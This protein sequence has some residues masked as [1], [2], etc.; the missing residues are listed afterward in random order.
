MSIEEL[1]LKNQGLVETQQSSGVKPNNVSTEE[2]DT[3]G[4]IIDGSS[5]STAS[6]T[7]STELVSEDDAVVGGELDITN[8]PFSMVDDSA[9][10]AEYMSLDTD[11]NGVLTKE[12]LLS[13]DGII[14]GINGTLDNLKSVFAGLGLKVDDASGSTSAPSN[15]GEANA[16]T[17]VPVENTQPA[18]SGEEIMPDAVKI[19]DLKDATKDEFKEVAKQSEELWKEIENIG[20]NDVFKLIDTDEDGKVSEEELQAIAELDSEDNEDGK[21]S[22]SIDDLKKAVEND[23]AAKA[24]E[25]KAQETAKAKEESNKTDTQAVKQNTSTPRSSGVSGGGRTGGASGAGGGSY[26]GGSSGVSGASTSDLPKVETLE[27][28]QQQKTQL[29]T[30]IADKQSEMS[31]ISAGTSDK[32]SA[33]K[34]AMEDAKKDME[35]AIKND[36][37][38]NKE[39]KDEYLELTNN[40]EKNNQAISENESET[41]QTESSISQTES[42]I[43][44]LESSLN[45][46]KLSGEEDDEQKAKIEARRSE[47][48]SQIADKKTELGELQDKKEQL[49]ADKSDL[50]KEKADLDKQKAELEKEVLKNASPETK[51]AIKTYNDKQEAFESKKTEALSTA[52]SELDTKV[53][54][55]SEVEQKINEKQDQ[56]AKGPT[57]DFEEGEYSEAEMAAFEANWAENKERYEAVAEK[58]GVPAELIA[59][60]HWREGSGNFDTYLHNGD[61]LGS[62]T[63]HV[64]AGIYFDNWEEAAIDAISSHRGDSTLTAD[65]T[66]LDAMAD[67]AERYNGLGYR[68]RG[69]P[70]A[71]VWAG[72]DQYTSGKFVADGQYDPNA[73]DQQLGVML[74]LKHIM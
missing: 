54:E 70:S 4:Y 35:D 48:E 59:A 44:T 30:E 42:S 15:D 69:V 20:M 73:V 24:E 25:A 18:E 49:V 16:S 21:D 56:E 64:P 9:I 61:P 10:K 7:E 41:M 50:E 36:D 74:M 31:E 28:L 67:F 37:K 5:T 8:N 11:N 45:S 32:V 33:E 27:E 29:E 26:G 3:S 2:A 72:T 68:N 51:T 60:I 1:R 22:I 62:P 71:Y 65:S 57:F 52:K 53:K 38:I 58:T 23:K 43:S 6:Q 17:D 19:D 63:T 13:W 66:D 39:T 55:L 34:Q 47:L 14:D 40:I 12:E 46:L